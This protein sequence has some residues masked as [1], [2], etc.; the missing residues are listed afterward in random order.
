MYNKMSNSKYCCKQCNKNYSKKTLLDQHQPFCVFIHTS[1]KEHENNSVV[2][3]SQE[4]MF[5]YIVHLTKKV[6][7][8]EEKLSRIEKSSTISKK[9]HINDYLKTIK[10]PLYTYSEWLSQI[11]VT[12]EDLEKLFEYDIKICIK[13]VL[14]DVIDS[15]MPFMAFQEKQNAIYIFDTKWRPMTTEEFSRLVSVLSHRILKKYM[16]WANEHREELES[17]PKSQELAMSYMSKAN[18]LNCSLEQTSSDIKKWIFT[19]ISTSN[20]ALE[21]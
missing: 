3:P 8:L 18:G 19:K 5:Q 7:H 6:E 1:A 16:S 12:D 11:E 17:N 2:L 14:S 4:I 15:D 20:K 9:T 10:A 21:Y 13:S